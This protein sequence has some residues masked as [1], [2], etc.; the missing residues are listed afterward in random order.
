VCTTLGQIETKGIVNYVFSLKE[1]KRRYDEGSP[2]TVDLVELR[3][4][5]QN[6]F[7]HVYLLIELYCNTFNT[8]FGRIRISEK[9]INGS[10]EVTAMTDQFSVYI[11]AAYRIPPDWKEKFETYIVEGRIYYGGNLLSVPERTSVLGDIRTNFFPQISWQCWMTFGIEIRKLPRESK[12][13]LTLYGLPPV[14][15]NGTM[16]PQQTPLGWTAIQLFDFN[17]H[18]VSG[19]Q[20]FG[21][22]P[23]QAANPL[24]TCTSNLI[25]K[26]SAILQIDF[27][28]HLS[29]IVFPALK[30]PEADTETSELAAT[31]MFNK[32]LSKDMFEDLRPEDIHMIWKNRHLASMVNIHGFFSSKHQAVLLTT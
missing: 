26:R 17:G 29:D 22:W 28:R 6:L 9:L 30:I 32:F 3:N 4:V 21:L 18:L 19:S 14:A 20:L 1:M 27:S 13:C 23:N 16:S 10:I 8:D 7:K 5:L 15:K 2:G 31:E 11:P 12:L 24:G 25:D